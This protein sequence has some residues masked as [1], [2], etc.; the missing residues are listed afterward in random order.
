M[1]SG[2]VR[3]VGPIKGGGLSQPELAQPRSPRAVLEER[4]VLYA[5]YAA[6]MAEQEVALEAGNVDEFTSLNA[7]R[8]E[9]EAQVE[10]LTLD[11][12]MVPD[13]E[14]LERVHKAVDALQSVQSRQIRME[15]KLKELR[16]EVSDEIR[17]VRSRKL[18]LRVYL[19]DPGR[20]AVEQPRR[21][22]VKS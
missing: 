9:I 14:A 13:A 3:G 8:N 5:R 4:L 18:P 21:I 6:V 10:T 12:R 1:A 11:P 17:D 19:Q 16:S 20:G 15:E 2:G 7:A 22:D